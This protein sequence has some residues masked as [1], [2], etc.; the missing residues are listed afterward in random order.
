MAVAPLGF[1]VETQDFASLP[2]SR[3]S[4]SETETSLCKLCKSIDLR[5]CQTLPTAIDI[6][7]GQR[8]EGV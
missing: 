6:H 3:R 8:L 4:L 1:I 5:K 7:Y 2:S